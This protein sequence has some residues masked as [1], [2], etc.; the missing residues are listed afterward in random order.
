MSIELS[1][2]GPALTAARLADVAGQDLPA[3][4]RDW[5]LE[6]NGGVLSESAHLP[7]DVSGVSVRAFLTVDDSAGRGGYDFADFLRS[8][9]GRYPEGFLPVAVDASSNLIL[10]DTGYEQPGSVWFWDHEGEADEDEPPRTDNIVKIADTFTEF[11]DRLT[12]GFTAEE[13]AFIREAA[14]RAT[15]TKGPYEPPGGFTFGEKK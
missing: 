12:T 13:E 4:Y 6:R 2:H 8:Y 15:V 3:D 11:L 1:R 10:L 14:A 5:M 9:E 7:G